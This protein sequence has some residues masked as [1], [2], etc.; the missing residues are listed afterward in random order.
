M[1]LYNCFCTVQLYN[2]F[3]CI[4]MCVC[5]CVCVCVCINLPR[6]R[7]QSHGHIFPKKK[8]GDVAQVNALED[9]EAGFMQSQPISATAGK[10]NPVTH[11]CHLF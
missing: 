2:C 6:P 5:V 7:I 11:A 3:V 9:E 1:C 10:W 8:V 4:H